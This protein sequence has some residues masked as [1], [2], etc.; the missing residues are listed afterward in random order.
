MILDGQVLGRP[1]ISY[2]DTQSAIEA[3]TGVVA[4][5]TAYAT[6]TT[7]TGYYT[8]S[9]WV[10]L[11]ATSGS[12]VPIVHDIAGA[13]HSTSGRTSGQVL[14]A[15][16]A[17]TFGWSSSTLS[18]SGNSTI[19]GSLVGNI[20]GGGTIATGGFTLTVPGTG[21]GALMSFANAGYL[22]IGATSDS[23]YLALGLNPAS[24]GSVRLPYGS[25]MSFRNSTN[26]GNVNVFAVLSGDNLRIGRDNTSPTNIYGGENIDLYYPSS[27][28]DISI[29]LAATTSSR[30]I[31]LNATKQNAGNY[32]LS[33]Y[34]NSAVTANAVFGIYGNGR[35]HV[36]VGEIDTT[37]GQTMTIKPYADRVALRIT[38]F[39][40][41]T[42]TRTL[43]HVIRNDTNTNALGTIAT[44]AHNSTGTAAAGFG[45]R[46]LW[47]L[48]SSTTADQTAATEDVLWTDATH[49]TRTVLKRGTTTGNATQS[50]Y[51]GSWAHNAVS[52]TS[53][54]IIP[55]GTGDVASVGTFLFSA[56]DNTSGTTNGGVVVLNPG[57]GAVSLLSD[58]TDTLQITCAADGSV[59]IARSAG[60]HTF[61]V[62]IWGSWQ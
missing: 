25:S 7:L 12:Y 33:A 8:G 6:D 38:G 47:T 41:Q 3:L 16:G 11:S 22:K 17:T 49:A 37:T 44:W 18:I 13:Y 62:S 14:Q 4:G 24:L 48:E 58:S 46:H 31:E 9:A 1:L 57:G 21:T 53:I 30:F 10:W 40:T 50:G 15:T 55:N 19:N 32:Y 52:N 27:T 2:K 34:V 51:Y 60:T 5:M 26:T 42:A 35:D 54:T 56:K 39:A 59:T 43:L 28:S 36:F 20:T 61:S 23:D 29:R 45:I